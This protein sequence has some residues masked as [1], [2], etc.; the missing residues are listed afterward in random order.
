MGDS[1]GVRAFV[2]ALTHKSKHRFASSTSFRP[3]TEKI[4]Q[5]STRAPVYAREGAA[6][7]AREG[8]AVYA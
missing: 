4:S 1:S 6:V 2:G 8:A 3:T 7:Y 5:K